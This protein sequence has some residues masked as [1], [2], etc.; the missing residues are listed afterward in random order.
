[1]RHYNADQTIK[2]SSSLLLLFDMPPDQAHFL[3]QL[4]LSTIRHFRIRKHFVAER[5]LEEVEG[6]R[7]VCVVSAKISSEECEDDSNTTAALVRV[8]RNE[9]I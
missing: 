3:T 9:S 5:V 6:A 1:M 2:R 8:I 7:Q 4:T